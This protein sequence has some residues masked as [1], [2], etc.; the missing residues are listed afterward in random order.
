[1][2]S[3]E[4]KRHGDLVE[5]V[6]LEI[7]GELQP[8]E[9]RALDEHVSRCED[10]RRIR[11]QM[12]VLSSALDDVKVEA[13][14]E[15]ARR[16]LENLPPTAWEM[17]RPRSWRFAMAAFVV[18]LGASLALTYESPPLGEALP[19]IGTLA[20]IGDMFRSA[21]LAGAGLLAASW[22]GVGLALGEVLSRSTFGYVVFGLFVLGL[23]FLL[24]RYLWRLS[25]RETSRVRK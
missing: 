8:G 10:C 1:M 5:L 16:V 21:T 18:L 7:D 20:A 9:R 17:R 6:Y 25:R 2:Q 14:P 12:P 11:A 13:H 19:W 3:N 24:A 4:S 15:L 22:S 23:D